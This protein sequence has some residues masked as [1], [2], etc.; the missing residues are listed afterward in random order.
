M[1]HPDRKFLFK[2]GT[3]LTMDAKVSN[4]ATGDVLVEGDRILAVRPNIEA[5]DAEVIDAAGSIVMPGLIDAHHHMWLGVMRR[6]SRL[7]GERRSDNLQP[8]LAVQDRK[9][10]YIST[11]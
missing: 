5:G 11:N 8:W 7:I 6:R 3:V 10:Q 1:S 2:N 4:L 9:N